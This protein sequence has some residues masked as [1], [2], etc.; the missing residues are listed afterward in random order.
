MLSIPVPDQ[1]M[2][3]NLYTDG[4]S[5]NQ[6]V[7]LTGYS[8]MTCHKYVQAAGIK[9]RYSYS[10]D[11]TMFDAVDS[12]HKAYW[13]GFISADGNVHNNQLAINLNPK[14]IEHLRKFRTFM[15]SDNPIY[16]R[17]VIS[18]GKPTQEVR[19]KIGSIKLCASLAKWGVVPAKFLILKPPT[20][21]PD[22]LEPH[23]WR[24]MVDGDGTI[25][26]YIAHNGKPQ[27]AIS[28]RSGNADTPQGFLDFVSKHIRTNAQ[29]CQDGEHTFKVS[30]GGIRL[31]QE[32]AS[33]LYGDSTVYLD[34]KY[35][36]YKQCMAA[37][38][39]WYRFPEEQL[40]ELVADE[41][42]SKDA[43]AER[44]G[45]D[46]GTVTRHCKKYGIEID[47]WERFNKRQQTDIDMDE[48]VELYE[49]GLS[50]R[51]VAKAVGI[52][53]PIVAKR[54]RQHGVEIRPR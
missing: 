9:S 4:N 42:L 2:I 48:A 45:T 11:E 19:F 3:A 50:L 27:W 44:L 47:W 6:I 36:L 12:E 38:R 41:S 33:L 18:F 34:R 29:V 53:H 17:D 51:K 43:I 37:P 22:E 14:D 35:E 52:S 1:K 54:F 31:P 46:S 40:R 24:G 30:F 28:L 20:G 39:I 13:L 21:L 15:S 10:M 16:E 7:E 26:T 23:F 49:A 25:R 32:V 5:Y 8:V